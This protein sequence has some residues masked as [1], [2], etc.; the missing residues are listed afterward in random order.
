MSDSEQQQVSVCLQLLLHTGPVGEGSRG[1]SQFGAYHHREHV[2][3]LHVTCVCLC[4]VQSCPPTQ[5]AEE[6]SESQ[7]PENGTEW[8]DAEEET[9]MD[10]GLL[11]AMAEEDEDINVH[12]EETFGAGGFRS[13]STQGVEWIVWFSG[14]DSLHTAKKRHFKGT[15]WHV[16]T[17]GHLRLIP[18]QLGCC[19]NLNI[20]VW[21]V[22]TCLNSQWSDKKC[23]ALIL[24][25]PLVQQGV[26]TVSLTHFV[27]SWPVVMIFFFSFGFHSRKLHNK[28]SHVVTLITDEHNQDWLIFIETSSFNSDN[29]HISKIFLKTRLSHRSRRE[30]DSR[31]PGRQSPFAW[32][33]AA[34]PRLHRHR[35][36]Y[37]TPPLR[38]TTAPPPLP[39][40][41]HRTCPG[42]PLGSA[43]GAGDTGAAWTGARCLRIQLWWG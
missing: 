9:H 5:Q 37:R 3:H 31:G 22:M 29:F 24:V 13:H 7:W 2:L 8:S 19:P 30:W 12:N 34:S 32:R 18:L 43:A 28:H 1:W 39:D 10:C 6:V 14:V 36:H 26:L 40:R 16:W 27:P 38:L 4:C 23:I 33:A 20:H 25:C 17:W 11:Q 15:L 41:S 42:P 21:P 35:H